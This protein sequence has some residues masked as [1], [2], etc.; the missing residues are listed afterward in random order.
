[1]T[2]QEAL[3]WV[4]TLLKQCADYAGDATA[5]GDLFGFVLEEITITDTHALKA[6]YNTLCALPPVDDVSV[7]QQWELVCRRYIELSMEHS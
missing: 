2:H 1:M 6:V 3:I 7:G 5:N 4:E